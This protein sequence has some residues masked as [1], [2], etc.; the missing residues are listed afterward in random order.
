MLTDLEKELSKQRTRER[1][2]A[3]REKNKEILAKKEKDWY[4]KNKEKASETSKAWREKNKEKIA[5]KN[6][7]WREKN[8]EKLA[9]QNKKRYQKNKK[10]IN[11]KSVEYN[12]ARKEIDPLFKLSHNIRSSINLVIKNGGYTKKAKTIQILGCS[13][14]EFKIHIEKQFTKGMNWE[15]R[16]L[17]HLDHKTPVSHA[18]SEKHLIEL[19][20][21]TNFQ[22]LWAEDNLKK[23]N[24]IDFV[25]TNQQTLS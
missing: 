1:T 9:K 23:G 3:W 7:N 11:K 22:P 5:E 2:K 24:K 15:N 13:F 16:H 20:H 18:V 14:E 12:K 21:Y 6:R 10:K 8:K 17:W 4:E 19:N 25:V